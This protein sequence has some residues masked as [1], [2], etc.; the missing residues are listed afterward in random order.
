MRPAHIYVGTGSPRFMQQDRVQPGLARHLEQPNGLALIQDG[1]LV[2]HDAGFF[3]GVG[4]D[5]NG[6]A[7]VFDVKGVFAKAVSPAAAALAAAVAAARSAASSRLPSRIE[8]HMRSASADAEGGGEVAT[9]RGAKHGGG[10][11]AG[12]SLAFS[13][14]LDTTASS[15]N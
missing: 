5:V 3:M 10:L 8:F 13:G 12:S 7:G 6:L 15:S 11:S 9:T 4:F 2:M 14:V 1:A